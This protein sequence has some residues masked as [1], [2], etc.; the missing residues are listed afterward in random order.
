M[1]DYLELGE[2][3]AS[4]FGTLQ[5]KEPTRFEAQPLPAGGMQALAFYD[6]TFEKGHGKILTQFRKVDKKW[7]LENFVVEPPDK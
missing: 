1:N 4:K 6:G 3:I 7:L 2:K 5:S